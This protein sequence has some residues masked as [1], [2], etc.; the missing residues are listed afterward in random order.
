MSQRCE[1]CAEWIIPRVLC[2]DCDPAIKVVLEAQRQ[3]IKRALNHASESLGAGRQAIV[4]RDEARKERDRSRRML[5][6]AL[7][8]NASLQLALQERK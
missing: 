3:L 8:A 4:E 6:D 7:E 2:E 1:V 5:G